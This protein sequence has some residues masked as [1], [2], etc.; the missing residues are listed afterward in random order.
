VRQRSPEDADDL[1]RLLE[2]VADRLRH[3]P[4]ARQAEI[5]PQVRPLLV[6]LAG[7]ALQ[8]EGEPAHPLPG[9]PPAALGDQV[10][11]LG[12]DLVAALRSRPSSRLTAGGYDVLVRVRRALP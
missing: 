6:E 12:R 10:Q 8:A 4:A 7:L 1:E 3:L 11:V 2:H 9:V 5:A